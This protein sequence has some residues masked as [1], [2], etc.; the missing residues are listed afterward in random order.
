MLALYV[1][2]SYLIGS[3]SAAILVC[4]ALGKGDPRQVGSGNPGATNVLRAFGKFPAALT[5]V[6]DVA[7]G[8]LP[9]WFGVVLG[10]PTYAIAGAGLAAFLGH[11]FPVFFGFRGGKG[12]ATL[13]GVQFGFDWRIAMSF[14]VSWLFVAAVTRYSS[15]AALVATAS[16]PIV[17]YLLKLPTALILALLVMTIAVFARHRPNIQ[18]LLAGS[19]GKIGAK[20][21]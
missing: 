9:V 20:K 13:I 15:L 21:P 19:E 1:V 12:V 2:A 7:K 10:L 3:L 4:R 16:A 8:L 6:G 11:L 17:A 5:L 14:I 18:R